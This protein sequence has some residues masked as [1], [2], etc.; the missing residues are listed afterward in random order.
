MAGRDPL[1]PNAG[2]I[3]RREYR[4]RVHSPLFV[5]STIVL[6]GLAMLAAL[7]PIGIRSVDRQ[8]VTQI[9]IESN[10]Q[11]LA[12]RAASVADS[13][14]NVPPAGVTDPELQASVRGRG[15]DRP[16]RHRGAT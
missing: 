4:D 10:D 12:N 1:L 6:A 3:A 15:R 9:A 7:A 13:V 14:L 5:V 16:R 11:D 8:T 2:I